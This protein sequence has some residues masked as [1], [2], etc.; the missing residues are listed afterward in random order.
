MEIKSFRADVVG[1]NYKNEFA[2][3]AFNL[4]F[5]AGIST[6]A[7]SIVGYPDETREL[8]FDTIELARKLKC[9]DLN[10]FTFAP[11]HGT[12]LRLLCEDKNL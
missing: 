7:N 11:Y 1:R 10:A 3:K 4:M 8:V 12:N 2:I 6:V 9:D 5:D